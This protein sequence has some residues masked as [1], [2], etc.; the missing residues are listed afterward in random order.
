VPWR[1]AELLVVDLE[2]TGLDPRRDEILSFGA[3][4]V[5]G[6][7]LLAGSAA[8]GLARPTRPV[9]PSSTVVHAL[10]DVDLAG[11][12][13]LTAAMQRL[14]EL[15]EG[16]LLV[17]HSAWVE[18]GFLAPALAGIGCRLAGPHVDTAALARACDLAGPRG[19]PDL[20]GLAG[21]LGLPVHGTHHALGD[22]LTTGT[23]LLALAT[24]LERSGRGT[25]RDLWAI[26]R[27]D[28]AAG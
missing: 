13:P 25:A 17:A 9:P 11:A 4:V 27:R 10:R 24:R 22:A 14:A 26:T 1:E 21:R 20:E 28:S 7:R 3:V 6:G 8:Y 2:T 19:E 12:P 18:L 16:R 5:S 23:V 15:L